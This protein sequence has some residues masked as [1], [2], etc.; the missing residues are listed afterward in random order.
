MTSAARPPGGSSLRPGAVPRRV[1]RVDQPL[2]LITQA[3]R[4]GGTLV[5]RL[6]DGH[7]QCHV[8]PFQFRGIDR[9]IR[10]GV[11]E[12]LE[13]WRALYNSK[14]VARS[15]H[16]HR[17]Q[18]HGVLDDENVFPFRLPPDLH[19]A[20]YDECVGGLEQPGTRSLIEC[21]LTAFF[22]AWLDYEN[23]AGNKRWVLAFEP[24]VSRG[25]ARRTRVRDLYPDGR[26]I[27]VVRDPWSWYA[28]ASR[29]EPRWRDRDRAIEHWCRVA[30][31]IRS[32]KRSLG[33]DL[34]LIR[35]DDLLLHTETTMR[36][37]AE[38]LEIEFAPSL[39][40]PTFNGLPIQANTSFADV[41]TEVSAKPLERAREQLSEDDMAFI[42]QRAGRLYNRLLFRVRKDEALLAADHGS[43]DSTG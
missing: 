19:R 37:L 34:R 11:A 32:W 6:L 7:P 12:P 23:L 4:S 18:K 10:D 38:W 36:S 28:S 2:V 17:Q 14:L 15:R 40:R 21:Y 43:P 9:A 26:L 20:L 39:L 16:G 27:S 25:A 5:Q 3:Q 13:A 35:F 30:D 22:N 31:G 8:F 33:T 41:A 1:V 42:N 29:W 24:G